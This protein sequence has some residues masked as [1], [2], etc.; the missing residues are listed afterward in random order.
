MTRL[1]AQQKGV[2]HM[3]QFM[4]V[5]AGFIGAT[6]EQLDEVHAKDLE[7]QGAEGVEFHK[8]WLDPETGKAFCLSTAPS[9]EA[10]MRVHEKSGIPTTEVY[11]IR[12]EV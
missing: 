11:E 1:E 7:F 12:A 6:Q 9:K 2:P 8:A 5:H 4:D 3:A 10:I